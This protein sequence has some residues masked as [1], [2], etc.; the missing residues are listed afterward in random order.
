MRVQRL[1]GFAI[2]AASLLFLPALAGCSRQA[3]PGD[4][5]TGQG[6]HEFARSFPFGF[7]PGERYHY[8]LN[9]TPAGEE[10][11]EAKEGSVNLA[12]DH[13]G[14]ADLTLS[15]RIEL[16][17]EVVSGSVTDRFDNLIYSFHQQKTGP[18]ADILGETV[19]ANLWPLYF[20][21]QELTAGLQWEVYT[22][23]CCGGCLLE[24]TVEDET[25][26]AGRQGLSGFWLAAGLDRGR[27]CVS[28]D[29][30][31]PLSMTLF[32]LTATYEAVLVSAEGL[33]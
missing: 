6:G 7:T 2:L 29:V 26:V 5:Q 10:P 22:D 20:A 15:Y 24:F 1:V 31:L 33:E 32:T 21:D 18:L 14:G 17:G 23:A 30:P 25:T 12:V 28:P 9:V 4:N 16:A 27:F 3:E 19:L 13:A 8:A 11:G